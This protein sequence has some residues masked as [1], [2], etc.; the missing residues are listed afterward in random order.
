LIDFYFKI[1]VSIYFNITLIIFFVAPAKVEKPAGPVNAE[2]GGKAVI[3]CSISGNPV[4]TATW[5]KGDKCLQ[6]NSRIHIQTQDDRTIL[7]ITNVHFRD[8][9]EYKCVVKN[10]GGHDTC[11]ITLIVEDS[12]DICSSIYVIFTLT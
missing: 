8:E 6:N 4:P 12:G 7:T 10:D 1:V 9:A 2:A 5:Y 11:H 3:E